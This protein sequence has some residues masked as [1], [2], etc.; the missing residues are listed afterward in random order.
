MPNPRRAVQEAHEKFNVN[1]L[2]D[3][4]NK[5]HRSEFKVISEPNP[6]EAIIQSGKTTRWVEVVTAFWNSA[7]AK[8]LYS[9]ATEGEEHKPIGDG[10]FM[11]V[12]PEFAKNFVTAVQSKLE[13]TAYEKFRDE[14]GPGYLLVSIQ[15]PFFGKNAFD[16]IDRE[17]RAHEIQ[18]CGCFRS[19]YLAYRVFNGYRVMKWQPPA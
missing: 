5:R 14:Y 17:W 9:H 8:D 18:D 15:F 10:L 11:N 19:I 12:T 13:K 2:V 4:L 6:P 7:F 3:T 1:L 16:F